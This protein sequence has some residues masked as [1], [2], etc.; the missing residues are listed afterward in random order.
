MY[1]KD[2]HECNT[3]IY[4]PALKQISPTNRIGGVMVSMPASASSVV[5]LSFESNQRLLVLNWFLLLL[6]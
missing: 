6:R 5:D 2:Q 4:I 1:I 3:K